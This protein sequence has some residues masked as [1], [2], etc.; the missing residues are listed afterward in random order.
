[1]LYDLLKKCVSVFFN[2]LNFMMGGRLP[3]FGTASVVVE[4]NDY[5]LVVELPGK[6]VVFPGGFMQ[7]QEHPQQ[8]AARE[9]KEET[10]L[11]LQVGD[12]IGYYTTMSNSW[13]HMSNI[14]FV[15][16]AEVGGGTLRANAE[17]RPFWLH[18]S[19]LRPLLSDHSRHILDDYLRY[20]EGRRMQISGSTTRVLVPLA[21]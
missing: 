13:T 20:R 2:I 10:G 11:G 1:M 8:A 21:S 16:Q 6:R 15:F 18:E 14:S 12:L 9:G 5:Y 4:R 3:P 7:W 19:E 17:G